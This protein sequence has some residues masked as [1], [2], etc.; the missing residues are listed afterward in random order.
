MAFKQELP[1]PPIDTPDGSQFSSRS[2][3]KR[4]RAQR[5]SANSSENGDWNGFGKPGSSN[6]NTETIS[7]TLQN[8]QRDDV[9][10]GVDPFNDVKTQEMQER[11]GSGLLQSFTS[12]S[13]KKDVINDSM[14]IEDT[15]GNDIQHQKPT[16][17]NPK[18]SGA[19]VKR[20]GFVE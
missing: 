11:S 17:E 16:S 12:N 9:I 3:G 13:G 2:P 20:V 5:S 19:P 15:E 1:S 4:K 7:A 14:E 18:D 10:M 6:G 8:N